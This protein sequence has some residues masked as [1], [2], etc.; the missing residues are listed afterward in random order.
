MMTKA[1]LDTLNW[2]EQIGVDISLANEPFDKTVGLDQLLDKIHEGQ[3]DHEGKDKKPAPYKKANA[4]EPALGLATGL[5]Q[6]KKV[7]ASC[8]DLQELRTALDNFESCALKDTATNL[9]FGDGNPKS[10]I[11]FIGESPGS[12]EDMQGLPFVG[13]S[14]QLF[15]HMLSFIGL[16]S[17]DDYYITNTIPWRPP[18]NRSPSASE[19]A[20]LDPFLKRHIELV[21]PKV[22][23]LVGGVAAKHCLE[24]KAGITKLR[25]QWFDLNIGDD[26]IISTLAMLHPAYLLRNPAKKREAWLDLIALRQKLD[27]LKLT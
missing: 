4:P 14:G 22:I 8:Q 23:V 13:V 21:D 2:Y 24:E 27:A 18:G 15:E 11:M 3:A 9:V 20:L 12:D 17:R 1:I 7:A 26:K 10:G 25:G 5:E 16:K 6:A 19:L